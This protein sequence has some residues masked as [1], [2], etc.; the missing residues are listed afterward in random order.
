MDIPDKGQSQEGALDGEVEPHDQDLE[1][2]EPEN[3][4]WEMA[5]NPVDIQDMFQAAPARPQAPDPSDPFLPL[6]ASESEVGPLTLLKKAVCW[7]KPELNCSMKR[8]RGKQTVCPISIMLARVIRQPSESCQFKVDRGTY[9]NGL[10]AYLTACR[11]VVGRLPA[12]ERT[13]LKD[14]FNEMRQRSTAAV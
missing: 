14:V 4:P 11:R 6:C 7:E 12:R 8:A 9:A 10:Q 3:D 5:A 13:R 2:S 1:K